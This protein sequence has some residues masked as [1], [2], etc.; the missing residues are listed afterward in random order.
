L[1]TSASTRERIQPSSGHWSRL[2]RGLRG[3]LTTAVLWTGPKTARSIA[4]FHGLKS[5]HDQRGWNAL[6]AIGYTRSPAVTSLLWIAQARN[7]RQAAPR[8]TGSRPTLA[9]L[10]T[11]ER[12]NSLFVS[13]NS[14]FRENNSLFGCA[15]NLAGKALK[16]LL[17]WTLE[18]QNW[19]RIN[20]KFARTAPS[21]A[22]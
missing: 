5:V 16:L 20:L 4:K 17:H 1:A 19:A 10:P 8:E 11:S 3:H 7:T 18:S 14:L 15:G 9:Q 2:K 22:D 6:I 21:R 13:N 12:E